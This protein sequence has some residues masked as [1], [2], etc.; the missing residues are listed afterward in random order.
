MRSFSPANYV[1]RLDCF[2]CNFYPATSTG[3]LVGVRSGSE[4]LVLM[5]TVIVGLFGVC[6]LKFLAFSFADLCVSDT[7]DALGDVFILQVFC[8]FF[9][10]RPSI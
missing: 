9:P 4:K 10:R 5:E 8:P 2:S 3:S 7:L 1:L 6:L